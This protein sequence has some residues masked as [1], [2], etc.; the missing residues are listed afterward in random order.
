M[1]R[2]VI[3]EIVRIGDDLYALDLLAHAVAVKD[4]SAHDHGSQV[5]FACK[6]PDGFLHGVFHADDQHGIVDVN[7][8]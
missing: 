8:I 3:V 4:D 1:L 7:V 6:L 5:V 2:H